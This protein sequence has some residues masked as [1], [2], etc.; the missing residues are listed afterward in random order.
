M[1]HT[2]ESYRIFPYIAWILVI[3]FAL[4]TYALTVRV[5]KEISGI[6]SNIDDL[7]M[8][9]ERLEQSKSAPTPAP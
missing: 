7:E 9:V 6:G 1:G 4:F 5:N 3:G 8:R 2:L